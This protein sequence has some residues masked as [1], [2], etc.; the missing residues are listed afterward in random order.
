M[1][2]VCSHHFANSTVAIITL[3]VIP[4]YHWPICLMICFILFVRLSFSYWLWRRVI[5]YTLFWLSAH[6]RCD[7]STEDAYYSAAPDSTF[8]FV[9]GPCCPT[10][11]FVFAFWIV[12]AFCT[13][14][15]SLF[16]IILECP[17]FKESGPSIVDRSSSLLWIVTLYVGT[18]IM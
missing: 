3:F 11:D 16:C 5:P 15:T 17:Q 7:R 10:L 6:G 8:T 2:L 13:L 18:F 14:L 12:I 9:G 4:K 1:N